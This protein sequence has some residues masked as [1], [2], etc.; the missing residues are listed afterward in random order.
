MRHEGKKNVTKS[1]EQ[2][3]R[4]L[5][6][7][8]GEYNKIT[9]ALIVLLLCVLCGAYF[10][11]AKAALPETIEGFLL[12]VIAN[13][14]PVIIVLVVSYSLLR[15]VI[16]LEEEDK[17]KTIAAEITDQWGPTVRSRE[18]AAQTEEL[19]STLGGRLQPRCEDLSN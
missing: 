1:G 17:I 16:K 8:P 7:R 10:V 9:L 12:S 19:A 13:V 14:I 11:V 6:R 2:R 5:N 4:R 3:A 18:P 15:Q